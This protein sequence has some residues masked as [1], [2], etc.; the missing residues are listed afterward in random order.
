MNGDGAGPNQGNFIPDQ[1]PG[2]QYGGQPLGQ[3][4]D[5]K[6]FMGCNTWTQKMGYKK[7]NDN[8]FPGL[9]DEFA[10]TPSPNPSQ[11]LEDEK[12]H[13]AE[14]KDNGPGHWVYEGAGPQEPRD[15]NPGDGGF[16]KPFMGD[17]DRLRQ[18]MDEHRPEMPPKKSIMDGHKKMYRP[19]IDKDKPELPPKTSIMPKTHKKM[20]RDLMDGHLPKLPPM[21]PIKDFQG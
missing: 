21:K 17:R 19:L 5:P 4:D 16:G 15:L 20:P 3:A 8:L 13:G 18:L 10:G 7:P 14:D 11:E 6:G 2:I 1:A 12:P 9:P